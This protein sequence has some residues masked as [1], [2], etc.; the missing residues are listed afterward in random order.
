MS[1]A[2][3]D[4]NQTNEYKY[5]HRGPSAVAEKGRSED[6][7]VHKNSAA[8]EWHEHKKKLRVLRAS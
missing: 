4:R 7:N 8:Y 2:G 3:G 1:F 6:E 5:E